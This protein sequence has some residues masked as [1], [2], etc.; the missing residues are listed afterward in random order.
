MRKVNR[1]QVVG[2]SLIFFILS[3]VTCNLSPVFASESSPSADIRTKLEELK[4][5][6]ASKAAKLK[7]E[8]SK[9][10]TN[11]AYV[12]N[13]KSISSSSLTLASTAGPK[14]VTINQ[15]TIYE[16]KVKSKTTRPSSGGKTKFSQ[17]SLSEED[18]IAALGDVDETGVLTAKKIV[19]LPTPNTEQKTYLWGQI[20][21]ASEELFT[22][23]DSSGKNVAVSIPSE[24]KLKLNDLI[25]ATGTVN[26]NS[27]F[28]ADFVHVIQHGGIL[29]PKKVASPSA[30]LKP[31]T[32]PKAASKSA[33]PR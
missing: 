1:F 4:K 15:D 26:K 3:T 27:I 23:K 13:L 16:G 21:S 28:E 14:L 6:V 12:G 24:Y 8:V 2:Y 11:K 7:Q 5:E 17:K 18:Y 19:L 22:L 31:T 32:A 29:K 25:I 9:K 20:I 33:T 30:T 10:L